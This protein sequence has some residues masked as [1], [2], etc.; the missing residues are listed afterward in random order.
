[1]RHMHHMHHM[2][3]VHPSAEADPRHLLTV[4]HPGGDRSRA[5]SAAAETIAP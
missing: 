5:L 3:H 1:M 2:R 4:P